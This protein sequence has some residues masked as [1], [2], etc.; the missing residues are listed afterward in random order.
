MVELYVAVG[1]AKDASNEKRFVR[2]GLVA[3]AEPPSY[4]LL[5][6]K[7]RSLGRWNKRNISL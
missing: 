3:V 2:P 7:P 5:G 6:K 1:V 4:W